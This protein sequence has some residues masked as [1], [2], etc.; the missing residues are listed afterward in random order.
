MSTALNCWKPISGILC[1]VNALKVETF[2]EEPCGLGKK[3]LGDLDSVLGKLV[4]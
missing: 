1:H 3:I 2:L 4:S